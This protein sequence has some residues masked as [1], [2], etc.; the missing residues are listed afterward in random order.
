MPQAEDR[1][2]LRECSSQPAA[3]GSI[4][5]VYALQDI[6]TDITIVHCKNRFTHCHATRPIDHGQHSEHPQ[7]S[8]SLAA[9]WAKNK[10]RKKIQVPRFR[11]R[12]VGV[13]S[14]PLGKDV[15]VCSKPGLAL[16]S[17]EQL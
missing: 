11:G 5:P 10:N 1:I 7:V 9:K 6:G 14:L 3:P 15:R 4:A 13:P 12:S 17:S 8:T 16:N 2:S